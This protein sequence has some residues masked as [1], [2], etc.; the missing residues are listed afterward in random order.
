MKRITLLNAA[1]DALLVTAAFLCCVWLKPGAGRSYVLMNAGALAIFLVLWVSVSTI[2][3][4]YQFALLYN[5][6]QSA[7]RLLVVNLGIASLLAL[8][9]YF[10]RRYE[11]SRFVVFGTVGTATVVEMILIAMHRHVHKLPTIRETSRTYQLYQRM[12]GEDQLEKLKLE[13]LPELV[14]DN[15]P[16]EMQRA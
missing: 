4:K 8:L 2:T 12:V 11:F 5:L 10:T 7:W 13:P 6:K 3:H 9:M 14:P 16:E 1:F 15:L